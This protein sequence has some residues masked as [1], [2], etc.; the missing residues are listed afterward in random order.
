MQKAKKYLYPLSIL[1]LLGV[2]GFQAYFDYQV[3][4]TNGAVVAHITTIE[5]FIQ[6]ELPTQMAHFNG[7][8]TPLPAETNTKK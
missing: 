3:R 7:Q 1:I 5:K 6:Q 4:L 2:I 8:A